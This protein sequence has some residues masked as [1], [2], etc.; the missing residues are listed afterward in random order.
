MNGDAG[1]TRRVRRVVLVA[2]DEGTTR[3]LTRASLESAGFSVVEALDGEEAV[4]AY[5]RTLPDLVIL[6]VQMPRK[7]GIALKP[8]ASVKEAPDVLADQAKQLAAALR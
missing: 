7:D 6:D 1:R 8:P 4:A 2:D 3:L 5:A